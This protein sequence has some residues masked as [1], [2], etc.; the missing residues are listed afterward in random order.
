MHFTKLLALAGLAS[1]MPTSLQ[2]RQT[3]ETL[4]L[5]NFRRWCDDTQNNCTYEFILKNSKG[6]ELPCK[7]TDYVKPWESG[8]SARFSS[9]SNLECQPGKNLPIYINIGYDR[10]GNFWVVVPVNTAIRRNAFFGY[11]AQE[12]RDY[13]I[14]R[15]DKTSKSLVIG[16]WSKRLTLPEAAPIAEADPEAEAAALAEPEAELAERAHLGGWT[17]KKLH[18][19]E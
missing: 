3:T 19:G 10:P 14:V 7:F 11:N 13:N 17:V 18:R 1:A 12:I 6:D 8:R 9:P 2:V 5:K 16:T 15:P 4:T